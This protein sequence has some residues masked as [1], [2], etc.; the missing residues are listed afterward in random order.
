MTESEIHEIARQ[1][2]REAVK[3]TFLTL[4][5]DPNKPIEAQA[6]MQFLRRT[7]EGSET[8]KRQSVMVAAGAITLAVLGLIWASIK[9]HP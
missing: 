7:R 8:F 1:A 3:E 9:S 6:D 5:L 4:G 2:A